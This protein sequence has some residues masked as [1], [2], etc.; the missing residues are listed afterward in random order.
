MVLRL[1]YETHATTVDNE[2]GIATGW[3]PGE[4]SAA[5]R[6]NALALGRRRRDDG[7]D[8]VLSSDLARAMQTVQ[9]AF[10]GTDIVV[11]TDPRLREVDYGDLTGAP[12]DVMDRAR[13]A[14][15]DTPFPGGQS[16]REV[17]AGVRTLLHELLRDHDGQ[18]VL[19]VG[20][21]ATRFALDFLLTGRPLEVAITTPFDWREGWTYSVTAL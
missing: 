12:V 7:L 13:V 16:Y 11:G 5:G 15:I 9:I 4:L 20:H 6:D 3:L 8:L 2:N 1:V 10:A 18:R 14:H 21:A 19:L 17:T